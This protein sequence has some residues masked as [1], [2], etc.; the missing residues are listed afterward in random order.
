MPFANPFRPPYTS[1]AGRRLLAAIGVGGALAIAYVWLSMVRMPGI[2]YAGPLPPLTADESA[3]ADELRNGVN[4]LATDIG[5]RSTLRGLG[6]AAD[7]LERELATAGYDV[8]RQTYD[9]R[10]GATC[11]N[12]EV[13]LFGDAHRDEI[14][15][16]GAHYDSVVGT[17]GADDNASGAAAVLA[18][19]RAFSGKKTD[20]TLRFVEFANEEPP[21]F[22]TESMGSL[23]YARRSQAR[24]ERIVAMIS[25]ETI[26]YFSSA[27][28]TQKYPPP[29]D[30]FYPSTGDFIAIVGDTASRDLVWQTIAT[31]RSTTE[32]PSQG[33][34]APAWV[35]GIGWSDHWSFWQAGYPAIMVTDTAPYRLPS[36]HSSGD[37]PEVIDYERMA[38]VVAGIERVVGEI[39][40]RR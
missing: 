21:Y 22:Q 2:S 5:E 18:L 19:A 9:T 17:P 1:P 29:F 25:L 13:E 15:V 16:V 24:G 38:R 20:R 23:V 39:V 4:L 30:L 27:S 6:K 32:F 35:P 12:L 36:Y 11:D 33:T 26:G 3:L 31:F 40:G 37:T 7:A 34:S 8:Q 28:D 10:D 14:V